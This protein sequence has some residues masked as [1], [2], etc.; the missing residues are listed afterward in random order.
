MRKCAVYLIPLLSVSTAFAGEGIFS[1]GVSGSIGTT[2]Y[3]GYKNKQDALPILQYQN[4]HFYIQGLGAG[5][6]FWQSQDQNQ[7]LLLGAS[8]SP[9]SFKASKSSD[10]RMK[11]L[12]N[13]KA[14]VMAD[15]VYNIHSLY[16]SLENALSWDILGRSKGILATTQYGIYWDI[17]PKLTIKTAVGLAY[18]NAKYNRYYYGVSEIESQRSGFRTY[19]PKSSIQPYIELTANYDFTKNLSVF[20][21]IRSDKLAKTIRN[22][23]ITNDKY[24][25]E[26]SLGLLYSF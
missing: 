4:D 22:S 26:A 7:E 1:V 16:G 9:H 6:K 14:T 12:N 18:A 24:Q 17:A 13:R 3:I 10:E 21:S 11:R 23:P 19:K 8:Y 2:P 25:S 5:I 20:A 15:V